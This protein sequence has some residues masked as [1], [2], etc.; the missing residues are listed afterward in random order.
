MTTNTAVQVND[1]EFSE[2]DSSALNALLQ[3][4]SAAYD[5]W[6]ILE[7]AAMW[8][9]NHYLASPVETVINARVALRTETKK[10]KEGCLTSLSAI[11]IYLLK[12]SATEDNVATVEINIRNLIQSSLRATDYAQKQ[13]TKTSRCGSVYTG[14]IWKH[15]FVEGV[16]SFICPTVRHWWSVLQHVSLEDLGK[17]ASSFTELQID[18]S[19]SNKRET[20]INKD[21]RTTLKDH[22]TRQSR[23]HLVLNMKRP[24]PPSFPLHRGA[25][26]LI[27]VIQSSAKAMSVNHLMA[28]VESW[29]SNLYQ[30][31]STDSTTFRRVCLT[32]NDKTWTRQ[33]IRNIASFFRTRN[34]NF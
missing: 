33:P 7:S 17:N 6:K 13:W 8:F 22:R 12:R 2:R 14:K 28:E 29:E 4:F 3:N 23:G 10:L 32:G 9:W 11:V 21:G 31:M 20:F 16:H 26:S 30:T 25:S 1:R 27:N 24:S 19:R 15:V 34:R 18:K 5:A